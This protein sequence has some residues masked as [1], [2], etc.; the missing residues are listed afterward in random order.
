MLESNIFFFFS[1]FFSIFLRIS[2]RRV[3]FEPNSG[4]KF[5]S[6]LFLGLSLPVLARNNAR[7]W[8]FNFLIFFAIFLAI[9]FPGPS[10]NGIQDWNFF[11]FVSTYLIPLCLKLI[12]ERGFLIFLIF[13]LFFWELFCPSRVWTEFGTKTF[14]LLSR[15][16]NPFWLKTMSKWGFLI[17]WIFMLFFAEFSCQGQVRTEFGTKIFFPLS[18]RILSRFG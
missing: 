18:R 10:M 5:F 6:F 11:L 4:L 16:L 8:F 15:H 3:K 17:L 7:K 1:F 12:P 2:M 14:F 9:F 13:F